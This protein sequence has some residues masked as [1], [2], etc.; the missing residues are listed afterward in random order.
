MT[1][2][3]TSPQG[4]VRT[5]FRRTGAPGRCIE[6]RP[7]P[8]TSHY[9]GHVGGREDDKLRP[10]GRLSWL[11][12]V[13][14]LAFLGGFLL[15]AQLWGVSR[16]YP[17]SPVAESLPAV[18]P[19]LAR[20]WFVALLVLLAMIAVVRQPRRYVLAFVALAGLLSLFDQSRWQPW[21]YQYLFMFAALA[22]YPWRERDPEKREAAL[23]VC[24]LIVA[25]TYFWSGLQKLNINFVEDLFPWLVTPLVALLPASSEGLLQSLAIAAP[26]VEAGI[27][28]GLLTRFRNVAVM[29]A[30]S[31]HI[32]IL[33]SLGPLGHD[34]NTVV[35]PWN[36]AMM[37]FVVTLFWRTENFPVRQILAPKPPFMVW[38]CS[39][40]VSCLCSTSSDFGTLTSRPR[41]TPA[42]SR[43]RR[44]TSARPQRTSSPRRSETPP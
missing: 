6:A 3:A 15:S 43:T 44:S 28:V 35:W 19:L 1:S 42:I 37:V 2:R 20:I 22:L 16:S 25:S 5:P 12:V 34:W 30:L 24:R 32:F 11:K 17:L 33:F 13:L 36:A 31:M 41:S 8:A 23:N 10:S 7:A 9:N 18:P 26:F 40:S 4:A 39:F 38:C 27:G 14:A 21:F 29:L